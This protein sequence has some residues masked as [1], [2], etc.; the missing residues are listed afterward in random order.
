M[1]KNID[2]I[3]SKKQ[4]T[5]LVTQCQITNQLLDTMKQISYCVNYF[6]VLLKAINE[7]YNKLK[8]ENINI[9]IVNEI[10]NCISMFQS[11]SSK[12]Q[13]LKLD[14]DIIIHNFD[15]ETKSNENI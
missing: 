15:S 14:L 10:A 5:K 3:H 1:S 2:Q 9:D 6:H 7:S 12:L 8:N 4:L 11:P 13:K